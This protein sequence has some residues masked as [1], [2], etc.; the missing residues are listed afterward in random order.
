MEE[1]EDYTYKDDPSVFPIKI[2]EHGEQFGFCPAKAK[3]DFR[4]IDLYHMLTICAETGQM[5]FPGSVVDQPFWVVDLLS[6]FLPKYDM[7]RFTAKAEM[8]LGDGK[9]QKGMLKNAQNKQKV[10]K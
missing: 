10:K 3:W 2:S 6:W 4:L 1:R 9:G 8:I 7:L 5:P